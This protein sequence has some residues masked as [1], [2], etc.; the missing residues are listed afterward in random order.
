MAER[1]APDQ[2]IAS[3]F[4]TSCGGLMIRRNNPLQPEPKQVMV[5]ETP[6]WGANRRWF[7]NR[8]IGKR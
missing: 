2:K 6:L 4:R 5:L 3:T 1:L 8:H 7:Q